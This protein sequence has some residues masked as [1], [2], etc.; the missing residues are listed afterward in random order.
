MDGDGVRGT[1]SRVVKGEYRMPKGLSLEAQDLISRLLQ[2]VLKGEPLVLWGI[3]LPAFNNYACI[4][5]SSTSH[6]S[7]HCVCVCVL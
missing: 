6:Y 2:K 5:F 7:T 1:L 3:S 4:S